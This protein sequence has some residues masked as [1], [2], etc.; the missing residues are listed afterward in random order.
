LDRQLWLTGFLV[1]YVLLATTAT[2]P[3][4]N[5][6][7]LS[8]F[9]DMVMTILQDNRNACATYCTVVDNMSAIIKA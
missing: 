2:T 3:A 7:E 8:E 4:T 1:R 5:A 6:S 9:K